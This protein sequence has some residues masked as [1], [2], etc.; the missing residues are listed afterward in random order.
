MNADWLTGNHGAVR[1]IGHANS[2]VL[3]EPGQEAPQDCSS[4]GCVRGGLRAYVL[5]REKVLAV[6]S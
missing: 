1:P 6:H 2:T 5:P 3:R 4:V